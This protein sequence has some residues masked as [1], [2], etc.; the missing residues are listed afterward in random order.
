LIIK[1]NMPSTTHS[2]FGHDTEALEVAKA[3]AQGIKGKTVLV[4]GA[5]KG[6]IAFTTLQAFVC[7]QSRHDPTVLKNTRLLNLQP[8]LLSQAELLLGLLRS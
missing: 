5:N 3:F 2:E 8:A 1:D 6:G 4:T 7:S